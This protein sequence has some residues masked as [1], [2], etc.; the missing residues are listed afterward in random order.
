MRPN[1]ASAPSRSRTPRPCP[2]TLSFPPKATPKGYNEVTT[3]ECR[4]N[5]SASRGSLSNAS[6]ARP[7]PDRHFCAGRPETPVKIRLSLLTEGPPHPRGLSQLFYD[8]ATLRQK[9]EGM[10]EEKRQKN[11]FFCECVNA[12]IRETGQSGARASPPAMGFLVPGFW[13]RGET[14]RDSAQAFWRETWLRAGT[15]AL[16]VPARPHFGVR[17]SVFSVRRSYLLPL[18]SPYFPTQKRLKTASRRSSL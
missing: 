9:R 15:P 11:K 5:P 16:P 1:P 2:S 14:F 17:C 8:R 6:R 12:L 13:L 18:T 3:K 10:Q 7:V 4:P